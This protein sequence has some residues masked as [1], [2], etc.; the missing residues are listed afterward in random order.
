MHFA[1]ARPDAI[2]AINQRWLLKFWM[3]H[4]GM[5]RVPCWQAVK[6]DDLASLA[7]HLSFLDVIGD[8]PP[9]FLIRYHGHLI[10]QASG[11]T[12]CR[13][14]YLDEVIPAARRDDALAPYAQ[15]VRSGA[16]AYTIQDLTDPAGRP[17][18]F[19]RLLLPFSRDG[20]TVDRILAAYEFV[21]VDGA[22][23]PRGLLS[24]TAVAPT[25]QLSATIKARAMA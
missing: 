14:R 6:P 15:A 16:P 9:R 18:Q 20:E 11:A 23:D 7:D 3:R 1:T 24:G 10:A 22:F 19:E 13:G 17:I 5:A 12:D 21:S 25:L 8:R 2:R 4:R